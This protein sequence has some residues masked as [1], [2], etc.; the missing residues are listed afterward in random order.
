MNDDDVLNVHYF[1]HTNPDEHMQGCSLSLAMLGCQYALSSHVKRQNPLWT[2]D[3]KPHDGP[4]ATALKG[5]YRALILNDDI[6][7]RL[8]SANDLNNILRTEFA[9]GIS[10]FDRVSFAKKLGVALSCLKDAEEALQ[11]VLLEAKMLAETSPMPGQMG[12]TP[13]GTGYMKN[14]NLQPGFGTLLLS[15]C[16]FLVT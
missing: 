1:D 7:D 5:L 2:K 10:H 12:L 13:R 16:L 4:F 14:Y 3:G 8:Q 11:K 9:A 15:Y 6:L